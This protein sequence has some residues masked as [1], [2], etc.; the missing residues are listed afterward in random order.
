[1]VVA[2]V[3]VSS[4]AQTHAMQRDAIERAAAARGEQVEEWYADTRS[5]GTM[6][7]EH[8]E[9][10]RGNVRAGRV[11]AL[12]VYALDRLTRTG[13]R[14]TLD[15]VE[16]LRAAGVRLVSIVD[17]FALEGPA[18]EV[19]LSV[20]AWAAKME[21]Q[22]IN[23]RI[24]S[25][26]EAVEARG[27]SWG[28]PPRMTPQERE[29]AWRMRDEGR[30]VRAIAVALKVPRATVARTLGKKNQGSAMSQKVGPSETA[31]S[32]PKRPRRSRKQGP[33]Q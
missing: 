22:R 25:S 12:Y 31:R 18:A 5:G 8:L 14:D 30:S 20:M 1:M 3:R 7:R 29:T 17:A 4:R 11:N 26:R 15:L 9:R 24:A 13:I 27:G 32:R 23:E 33:S 2:Y 28:R 10:L 6:D 19:I 16:E 21:R